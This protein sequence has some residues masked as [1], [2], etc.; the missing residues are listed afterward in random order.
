MTPNDNYKD[1][2]KAARAIETNKADEFLA[3]RDKMERLF[4]EH[5]FRDENIKNAAQPEILVMRLDGIGDFVMMSGFMRELRRNYPSSRIT[6]IVNR[7]ILDFV[8]LCPYVNEVIPFDVPKSKSS[9]AFEAWHDFIAYCS[10]HLWRYHFDW[11]FVPQWGG[12]K[13]LQFMLAFLSG[14]KNRVGFSQWIETVYVPLQG[15]ELDTAIAN[16]FLTHTLTNPPEIEHEADRC[17]FMLTALG[18]AVESTEL[19][20]WYSTN[21][22]IS[23][24]MKLGKNADKKTLAVLGIG[25]SKAV[26]RYPVEK[27]AAAMAEIIGRNAFIVL[28]G[29]ADV[30]KDA[31]TFSAMIKSDNIMSLVAKLSLRE[32][33]ALISLA[34]IYIGNDTGTAHIA[35]AVGT[36]AVVLYPEA[37]DKEHI[38]GAL[39]SNY[40]KFRPRGRHIALRPEHGLDGCAE[41]AYIYGGC[42]KDYPHCITQIDPAEIVR[43]YDELMSR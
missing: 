20:T 39:L 25:A 14:A 4:A 10:E 11:A 1:L 18:L 30:E 37:K 13:L 17:F 41:H 9:S 42:E 21:D 6:L 34:D 3:M 38:H 26:C 29:G 35:A 28:V 27:Y 5:G 31:S 2:L 19:E 16:S 12:E 22:K 7:N 43:A 36:P 33:A 8:S 40:V 24:G 32:T 15:I 23:A